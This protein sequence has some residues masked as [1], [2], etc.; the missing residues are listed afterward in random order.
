[1]RVPSVLTFCH[2]L[3]NPEESIEG[4]EAVRALSWSE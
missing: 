2:E 1:M 4:S 3:G